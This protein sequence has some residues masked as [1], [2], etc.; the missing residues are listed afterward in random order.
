MSI[1]MSIKEWLWGLL[2][3]ECEVKDCRGFGMRGNENRVYP[4]DH[5]PDF[6]IVMCDYC[7]SNY[8][9]GEVLQVQ[10]LHDRIIS[11]MST[12]TDLSQY[13]RRRSFE[14]TSED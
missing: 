5:V 12:V 10:G 6:F 1:Q 7:S 14:E 13:K 2:P 4:F 8:E 3:D 11:K 9:R